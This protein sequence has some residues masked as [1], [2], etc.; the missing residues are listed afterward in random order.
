MR[1]LFMI[2]FSAVLLALGSAQGTWAQKAKVYDLGHYS[3]GSWAELH[4][5]NDFGVAVGVGD[6]AGDNKRMIGV[7]LFGPNAGNWFESGISSSAVDEVL[8][9]ISDTGMIAGTITGDN[10]LPEAYAWMPNGTGYHLGTLPGGMASYA[11]AI[12]HTGT[13]IVGQSFATQDTGTVVGT[14]TVWTAKVNWTKGRPALTW[15]IHALPTN[16]LD[17]ADA[18]FKGVTLTLWGGW[19]VNDL[20]QIA[21][22]AYYYDPDLNE[23]WEIAVVW[24]P[25]KH[26]KE[27]EMQRLPMDANFAYS[28][29]LAINNSG[30]IVGDVWESNAYPAL[31]KRD[32][33]K[34]SWSE[35]QLPTTPALE[36]GWSIAWDINELGDIVGSCT[37]ENWI[38]KATRWNTHD[39][40]FVKLLG[41]PGDTN[42]VYGVNNLGIAVGGY[43]YFV[44]DANGNQEFDK[45]GNPIFSPEQAVATKLH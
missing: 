18:V 13:L 32:P 43:Q 17:V 28:E 22:D 27:W 1:R 11:Y 45:D 34:N 20:G 40:S 31:W 15:E 10:G 5:I 4:G 44:Y 26:G 6:V 3:G 7:P 19:G 35:Q 37:D 39:L 14:A 21:G 36:Y 8:P 12:N 16:G 24:N 9:A 38:G 2:L 33:R 25:I 23:W 30:D 42:T 41:L 29:A